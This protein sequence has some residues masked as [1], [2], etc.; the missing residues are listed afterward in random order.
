SLSSEIFVFRSDWRGTFAARE[1]PREGGGH[2]VGGIEL[3]ERHGVA[4]PCK[5]SALDCDDGWIF[6]RGARR[7]H[8][9]FEGAEFGIPEILQHPLKSMVT[10]RVEWVR[11]PECILCRVCGIKMRARNP[12]LRHQLRGRM[13]PLVM[14]QLG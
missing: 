5:A 8:L 13:C 2:P 3:P 6:S 4:R 1:P 10:G 11:T 12:A 9:L 7:K 14:E